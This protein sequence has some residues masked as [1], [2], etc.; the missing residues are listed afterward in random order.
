LARRQRLSG[1]QD[2]DIILVHVDG[3]RIANMGIATSD[4]APVEFKLDSFDHVFKERATQ[5]EWARIMSMREQPN[6]FNALKSYNSL[7]QPFFANKVILNKIVTEAWRFEM[8]VYTLYLYDQR[9]YGDSRSGLTVANLERLCAE[10]QCASPGR[11][12]AILGIMRVGGYLRRSRSYDDQRVIQLEPTPQF[13][14]IVEA[15]N[16]RIFQISDSV[17]KDDYLTQWH[18]RD[19]RLGWEMRRRG[20]ES[21]K[22]G[23]KL[24]DPFPEV[25]HFV[26]SDGGWMLLLHCASEALRMG[27]D[28]YIMPVSVDLR[29][30][31]ARYGV[32]RSHLRRLLESAHQVGLLTQAPRNGTN[33]VLSPL[34][35]ASYLTCMAAE[36]SFY[37]GHA[38]AYLL[39]SGLLDEHKDRDL[40]SA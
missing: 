21:L 4:I 24:L 39:E 37:R 25:F 28:R 14:D 11:V 30:F 36:I 27:K 32:S 23:W 12:R 10:M 18:T 13:L 8:L 35:L 26:S 40:K 3:Q 15:W 19:N 38:M 22:E 7:M 29:A 16:N 6:F 1:E 5:K 17:F 31:G 2:H 33:I 20:C 9:D 34:L